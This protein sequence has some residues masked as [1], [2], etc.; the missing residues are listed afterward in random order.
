V[1]SR[2][3]LPNYGQL[4]SLYYRYPVTCGGRF[5][6]GI[7]GAVNGLLIISL[8]RAYLSGSNLPGAGDD[9]TA[10]V[11]TGDIVV[12]AVEVPRTTIVD[13]YLPWLFI[14]LGFFMLIVAVRSRV[15]ILSEKGYRKIDYQAPLG[16]QKV[17]VAVK[18][19]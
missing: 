17:D 11:T 2:W 5:F 16:Y 19:G 12:Q 9:G 13:S 6:G 1:I 4:S 15:V 14:A 10:A 18:D 8:V 7:L 3:S